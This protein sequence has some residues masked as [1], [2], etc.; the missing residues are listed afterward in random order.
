LE[1]FSGELLGSVAWTNVS[2][3]W[4]PNS[5]ALND[6]LGIGMKFT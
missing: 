6:G 5:A 3:G 1:D 2:S 4:T